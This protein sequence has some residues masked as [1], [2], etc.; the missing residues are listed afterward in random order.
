MNMTELPSRVVELIESS[1]VAEFAT[2]SAVGIPID[3]PTNCFASD[4]LSSID[5]TTGMAY[6]AKAERARRNPKAGLL[7]EGLPGEPVVAIAGYAAV[8]DANLQANAE[9]YIAETGYE[10]ISFGLPWERGRKAVWYWTRIIIQVTPAKIMWWDSA[11]AMDGPPEVWQAPEYTV[12]PQSDP[13]PAGQTS[14]PLQWPQRAWQ[15]LA[16]DALG[17]NAPGHLTLCDAGGWP[18]PM[19]AQRIERSDTGFRLVIP[20]GAPWST[21]KATLTFQG[22]ETFVGD[23][24]LKNGEGQFA[25]ERA[26]PQHPMVTDP[27]EVIQPREEVRAKFM[28][29]LE[30]EANRRGQAIPTMPIELPKPTR[31]ALVRQTRAARILKSMQPESV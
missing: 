30:E 10:G 11:E 28:A 5:V 18:L 6:P 20:R 26:L 25:V 9:R 7:L 8:R 29:R 17:R 19:R 21:G 24:D 15:E 3:T 23:I 31:L 14:S 1:S 22:V 2:V 12:F 4:D 27:C 13:S 16:D